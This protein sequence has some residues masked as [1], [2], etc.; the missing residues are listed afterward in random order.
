ML[1]LGRDDTELKPAP[2]TTKHNNDPKQ[3]RQ[4]N[5]GKQRIEWSPLQLPFLF[6]KSFSHH[7]ERP[8]HRVRATEHRFWL[9]HRFWLTHRPWL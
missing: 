7:E 4:A 8:G 6:T 9:K 2:L 5:R 3:G 1:N